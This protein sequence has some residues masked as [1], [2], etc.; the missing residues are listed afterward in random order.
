MGTRANAKLDESIVQR[1]VFVQIDD[2]GMLGIRLD[3]VFPAAAAD[4]AG[5]RRKPDGD[6]SAD[7]TEESC[8][9][10]TGGDRGRIGLLFESRHFDR[11][12]RGG[13]VQQGDDHGPVVD[14]D[15][16][17]VGVQANVGHCF[18][19]SHMTDGRPLSGHGDP[20]QHDRRLSPKSIRQ[21][22]LPMPTWA[23]RLRQ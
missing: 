8:N 17:Q 15:F 6:F 23:G 9:G 3:R 18:A 5:R 1:V 10:M 2:A 14:H 20:S 16:D 21:R 13:D 11:R 7:T 19:V 4:G 12:R 22:R